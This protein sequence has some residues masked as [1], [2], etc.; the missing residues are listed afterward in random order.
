MKV[1][2]LDIDGVLVTGDHLIALKDAGQDS[3]DRSDDDRIFHHFNPDTIRELNRIT[4]KTGARLVISS[5][6]RFNGKDRIRALFKERGIQG[7]I[8]G[9]TD[10]QPSPKDS[11]GYEISD[12]LHRHRIE[13]YIILDDDSDM[14]PDQMDRLVKCDFKTGL[15]TELADKATTLLSA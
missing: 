1:I 11:R 13:T 4:N 14:R 5:T 7:H 8:T 2:F 10:L 9:M 15:T 3:Y 6:W 12:Y